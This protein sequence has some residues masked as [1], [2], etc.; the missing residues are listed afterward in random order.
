[1]SRLLIHDYP[2][3]VSPR[4]AV[5]IGLNEAIVLQQ[6][7][8]WLGTA[9]KERDGK[10]WIYNTQ[11]EWQAQFPFWSLNTVRRALPTAVRG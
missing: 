5:A 3:M 11:V 2:L 6:L 1:M 7:H 9:G 8:Y 10:R 4:L